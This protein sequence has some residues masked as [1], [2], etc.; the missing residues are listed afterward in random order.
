MHL[1]YNSD[2]YIRKLY[3]S[4]IWKSFL[5][6]NVIKRSSSRARCIC[7]GLNLNLHLFRCLSD[8]PWLWRD[9]VHAQAR[10]SHRRSSTP[11]VFV[12]ST[13]S[14]VLAHWFRIHDGWCSRTVDAREIPY[15]IETVHSISTKVLF[16]QALLCA[17]NN[18]IIWRSHISLTW[19]SF[20]TLPIYAYTGNRQRPLAIY[21]IKM[22][23]K[24][25][26]WKGFRDIGILAKYLK[27]LRYFWETQSTFRDMVI[28][29]FLKW[30][31]FWGYLPI[32]F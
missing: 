28:Q 9:C 16:F 1:G 23:D 11:V 14:R 2:H 26:P 21:L 22:K 6:F 27:R 3:W 20:A 17:S 10:R 30:G 8:R 13:R 7:F 18:V 24:M 19:V 29:S 5:I 25:R 12:K 4:H 31:K 32:S 15:G